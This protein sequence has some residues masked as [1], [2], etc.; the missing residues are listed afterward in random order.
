VIDTT[1]CMKLYA[2]QVRAWLEPH[3]DPRAGRLEGSLA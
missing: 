2:D 3:L 1:D